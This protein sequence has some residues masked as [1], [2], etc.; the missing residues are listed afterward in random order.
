MIMI[1]HKKVVKLRALK[2]QDWTHVDHNTQV[3]T[4]EI[5]LN[6]KDN[7]KKAVKRCKIRN[8]SFLF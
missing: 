7:N 1:V 5:T 6:N 4:I 8:D 2:G 3:L